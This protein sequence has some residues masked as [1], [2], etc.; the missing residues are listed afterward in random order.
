MKPIDKKHFSGKTEWGWEK[1]L[2]L[3]LWHDPKVLGIGTVR[4]LGHPGAFDLLGVTLDGTLVL[5]EA[6][7]VMKPA[8]VEKLEGKLKRIEGDVARYLDDDEHRWAGK[9]ARQW[10]DHS[11]DD[12]ARRCRKENP[13]HGCCELPGCFPYAWKHHL[14]GGPH[15]T[16]HGWSALLNSLTHTPNEHCD[17]KFNGKLAVFF[18]AYKVDGFA[19]HFDDVIKKWMQTSWKT[20]SV[21]LMDVTAWSNSG[22]PDCS[23]ECVSNAHTRTVW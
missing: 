11:S 21:T 19:E 13:P 3:C 14:S 8:Y 15:F 2:Y 7:D 10:R 20:V 4:W 17:V 18:V 6:K 1:P 12:M 16:K 5:V 23:L 9:N 22:T